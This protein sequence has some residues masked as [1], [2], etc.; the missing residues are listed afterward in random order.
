MIVTLS[1][2]GVVLSEVF[3]CTS[4]CMWYIYF[5]KRLLTPCSVH[6]FKVSSPGIHC[7]TYDITLLCTTHILLLLCPAADIH[8]VCT[9]KNH[10][11]SMLHY[12]E[13]YGI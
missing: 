11:Y 13:Q 6:N 2:R 5:V 12:T 1:E 10:V 3:T 8:T 7:T 9:V 4:V